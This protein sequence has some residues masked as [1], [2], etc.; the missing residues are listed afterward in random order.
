MKM[1]CTIL[2]EVDGWTELPLGEVYRSYHKTGR[3]MERYNINGGEGQ[4][5]Y[6]FYWCNGQL[7]NRCYYKNGNY[8]GL[9]E[10]H[11]S[12]GQLECRH[13]YKDGVLQ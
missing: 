7:M 5:L 1:G 12:N 13:I 10:R 9:Y 4:G 8:H 3:L 11:F 6:E 2:S